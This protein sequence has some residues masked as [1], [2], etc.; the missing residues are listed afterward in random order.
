M[1]GGGRGQGEGGRGRGRGARRCVSV[2]WEGEGED[3]VCQLLVSTMC[4]LELG[5]SLH[6]WG[7]VPGFWTGHVYPSD[8]VSVLALMHD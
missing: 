1:A 2:S 4:G 3:E 5:S 6:D 8:S 7:S